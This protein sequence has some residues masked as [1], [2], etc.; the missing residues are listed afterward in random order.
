[1][2]LSKKFMIVIT[3]AITAFNL[4]IFYLLGHRLNQLYLNSVL[5][6]ARAFYKQIIITRLWVSRHGGVFIPKTPHADINPYLPNPYRITA[7][8][9][10]LVLRNPAMVTRE[11]SELSLAMGKRFR[12]HITSLYPINPRNAPTPFEKEALLALSS[13]QR[14]GAE[15]PFLEYT[16]VEKIEGETY[17]H[18]F[19][20]LYTEESCLSCHGSQGYKVGDVRGGISILVPIDDFLQAKQ[21]N[22][23]MA[24]GGGF[25]A[26]I[27]VSL[28]VYFAFRGYIIRPLGLLE[29]SAHRIRAGNY[30]T[31]I[32]YQEDDEIGDLGRAMEK[33]RT[34]ILD[35]LQSIRLSEQKYRQLLEHS[36]EAIVVTDANDTIVEMNK[37]VSL[38]SKFHPRE[39]RH[40]SIHHLLN[41]NKRI[42]YRQEKTPKAFRHE[43]FESELMCKDGEKLPVE[44]AMVKPVHDR[45][46]GSVTIYYL[47][48]ISSRKRLE[49]YMIQTEKMYALGQL[50]AGIA[51]EIRNPLFA[52]RND[53]DY[54]RRK[55]EAESPL[56]EVYG[57]MEEGLS[58]LDHIVQAILDYSRPHRMQFDRYDL[59]ET[60]EKSLALVRKQ[61]QRHRIHIQTEIDETLPPV[62]MDAHQIEQVLVN[63]ITNAM[64]AV[65]GGEGHIIVR[66]RHLNDQ[67]VIQ[68]TDNG[69]GIPDSVLPRIFD[70]FFTMYP[71]G[72]GLGLTIVQRIIEQHSGTIQVESK[73]GHG[74]TFTVRLPLRQN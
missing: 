25:L 37:N 55:T 3:A 62:E 44:V 47:R 30:A 73:V 59:R 72:T 29:K 50:S 39:I 74:T 24:V 15:R 38:M 6:T 49:N 61:L 52:L 57:E 20:P 58:R 2:R 32:G 43:L 33:M 22:F 1:M 56:Q 42:D 51:H 68:I 31:S 36:P 64:R 21:V 9:D 12:F 67:A 5:E 28:L 46:G 23:M 41:L 66:A 11:L 71:D 70:P 27:L 16:R 69:C 19:G 10:T 53:L 17:F 60:I 40:Q 35:S 13:H 34:A 7:E 48:D 18:Y 14:D 63:L 45:A 65:S 26:S 54:L 4:G 8:G